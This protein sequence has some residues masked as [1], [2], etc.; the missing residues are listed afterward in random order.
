LLSEVAKTAGGR[1]ADVL[2]VAVAAVA[3]E[4]AEHFLHTRGFVRELWLHGLGLRAALP[5]P[6]EE[7]RVRTLIGAGRAENQRRRYT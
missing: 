4:E 6:E 7:K 1:T 3:T 5:P 2:A